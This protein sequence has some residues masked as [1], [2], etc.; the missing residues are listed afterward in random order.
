M[1][2][3]KPDTPATDHYGEWMNYLS[4]VL[5]Y[6][7]QV[8]DSTYLNKVFDSEITVWDG[9]VA[10]DVP[11]IYV[12]PRAEPIKELGMGKQQLDSRFRYD[13]IVENFN[14]IKDEARI[15][16]INILGDIVGLF[17]NNRTLTIDTTKTC[18]NL[19]LEIFDPIFVLDDESSD[20]YV[21]T[22]V[23]LTIWKSLTVP[24]PA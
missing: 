3:Q 24:V 9:L 14:P 12:L 22:S 18:R 19:E 10:L 20:M 15:D 21:Q 7:L 8:Q 6:L 16:A 11:H 4:D 2:V 23:E 5:V 1:P 13:I 17:L